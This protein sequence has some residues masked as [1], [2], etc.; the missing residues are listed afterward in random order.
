MN[1]TQTVPAWE[2]H[3][4]DIKVYAQIVE[5]ASLPEHERELRRLEEE[6]THIEREL[7]LVREQ[8][9]YASEYVQDIRHVLNGMDLKPTKAALE[10]FHKLVKHVDDETLFEV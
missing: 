3:D 6:N 5:E 9:H 8:N 2:K 7:E 10:D 4:F 1:T